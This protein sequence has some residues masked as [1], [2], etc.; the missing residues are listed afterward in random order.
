[1]AHHRSLNQSTFSDLVEGAQVDKHDL[2]ALVLDYLL[3]EGFSDAAVEFARETG[4][5]V[6]VDHDLVNE[7]LGIRQAVEDGRVQ[8]AVL[9]TNELDPEIL[10]NNVHLLFHLQLLRLVELIRSDNLDAALEFATHELAPRG[11]QNPEFLSDLER[12]MALLAF[13]DLA[14]YADDSSPSDKKPTLAPDTATLFEEAAFDPIK[15]LMKKAHRVQ[16]ARELNMAILENQGYG[17]DTK[18]SGLVR[19]MAWGEQKL[20]ESSGVP[21]PEAEQNKGRAWADAVLGDGLEC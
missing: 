16:V 7:R 6:D 1:M 15:G 19:L 12:A 8:E 13:P 11:A 4:L 18:L 17:T 3:I 14:R 9:R 20:V 5:P 2:N 10:D 21:V